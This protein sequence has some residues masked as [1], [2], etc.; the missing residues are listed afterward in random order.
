MGRA[1]TRSGRSSKLDI[2]YWSSVSYDRKT[3]RD[4]HERMFGFS[5]PEYIQ[6]DLIHVYVYK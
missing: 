1:K 6:N 5:I 3:E 2:I 4:L